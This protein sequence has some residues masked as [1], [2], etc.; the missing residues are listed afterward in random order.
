MVTR[1]RSPSQA[2]PD[3]RKTRKP[4][5]RSVGSRRGG[6]L[7]LPLAG[8]SLGFGYLHG[9]HFA[10]HCVTG[11]EGLVAGLHFEGLVACCREAEPFVCLDVILWYAFAIPVHHGEIELCLG[12]ALVGSLAKP[13]CGSARI[14][15]HALA[16]GID[17]A[18]PELGLGAALI[19]GLG[20]PLC[21]LWKVLRKAFAA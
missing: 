21:G 18:E 10:C 4:R 8:K 12:I 11:P 19:R 3:N 1:T 2:P 15:R 13:F 17:H 16:I 20:I 5:S 14:P 6:L 7:R 9:V